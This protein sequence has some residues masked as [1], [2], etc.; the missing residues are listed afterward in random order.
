MLLTDAG[1]EGV[2]ELYTVSFDSLVVEKIIADVFEHTVQYTNSYT[3]ERLWRRVYSTS[4]TQRPDVS[5][6]GNT[7]VEL[8]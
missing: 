5:M 4:F 2:G 1:I 6:M 8:I 3:I 7:K